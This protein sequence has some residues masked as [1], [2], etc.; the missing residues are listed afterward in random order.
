MC[1]YYESGKFKFGLKEFLNYY[2]SA[3]YIFVF[4]LNFQFCGTAGET[5]WVQWKKRKE[6]Q[7][8]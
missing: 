5:K 3:Q 1:L 4:S 7:T 2:I 8:G 6:A